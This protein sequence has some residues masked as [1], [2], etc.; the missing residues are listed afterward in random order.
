MGVFTYHTSG[1]KDLIL[2]YINSLPK[3]ECAIGYAIIDKLEKDGFD[4]LQF[5]DTR[6][7]KSKLWEIKFRK[8]NRIFYVRVEDKNVYLLHACKKHKEKVETFEIETAEKRIKEI[9]TSS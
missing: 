5:L 4:A 1:G 6:Q 3:D 8:Q 2:E 9:S 7:I